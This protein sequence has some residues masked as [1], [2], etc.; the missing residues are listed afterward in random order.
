M[1]VQAPCVMREA[2]ET[3]VYMRRAD[4]ALRPMAPQT[5]C[6]NHQCCQRQAL[7]LF[8]HA[9]VYSWCLSRLLCA[10]GLIWTQTG[11]RTCGSACLAQHRSCCS[12]S[13]QSW[14]NSSSSS[15][16]LQLSMGCFLRTSC[17]QTW[18]QPQQQQQR[19]A[20]RPRAL[21]QGCLGQLTSPPL[22]SGRPRKV[23]YFVLIEAQKTEVTCTTQAQTVL[24]PRLVTCFVQ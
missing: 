17:R 10:T 14:P 4:C 24:P 2:Q 19:R 21:A 13:C 16:S 9:G 7:A 15:C 3:R 23:S 22:H 1:C 12:R 8:P 20:C 18:R 6:C 11:H 5:T